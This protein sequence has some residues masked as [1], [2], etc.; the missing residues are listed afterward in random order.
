MVKAAALQED[1]G[2][3]TFTDIENTTN[4]EFR[5]AHPI[6]GSNISSSV[7]MAT[8]TGAPYRHIK[9][10]V[11]QCGCNMSNTQHHAAAS[12]TKAGNGTVSPLERRRRFQ[13]VGV[14]TRHAHTFRE[15]TN[16][17]RSTFDRGKQLPYPSLD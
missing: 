14:A 10:P 13:N 15:E 17:A 3:E 16:T 1:S 12:F 5:P 7:R 2:H 11:P 6:K 4:P 9:L 8:S